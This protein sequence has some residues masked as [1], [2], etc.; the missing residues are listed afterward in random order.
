MLK[1]EKVLTIQNYGFCLIFSYIRLVIV[2]GGGGEEKGGGGGNLILFC[3]N[4]I[5]V[6]TLIY[7]LFFAKLLLSKIV[8]ISCSLNKLPREN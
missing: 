7:R 1:M 2:G 3:G 4:P 6:H 8:K 5:C